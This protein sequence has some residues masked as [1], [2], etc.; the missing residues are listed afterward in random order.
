MTN[1]D[2]R[3]KNKKRAAA[4]ALRDAAIAEED[5]K[6]AQ[7]RL[8]NME[9]EE[10][11]SVQ[12]THDSLAMNRISEI[13]SS[14]RNKAQRKRDHKENVAKLLQSVHLAAAQLHKVGAQLP[15]EAEAEL[16]RNKLLKADAAAA[17]AKAKLKRTRAML[18]RLK[19]ARPIDNLTQHDRKKWE[20]VSQITQIDEE[21]RNGEGHQQVAAPTRYN[22]KQTRAYKDLVGNA[23]LNAMKTIHGN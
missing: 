17:Q 16:L 2:K 1:R 5:A 15:W 21:P 9:L 23:V 20:H 19:K 11:A 13:L 3:N 14:F 7:K 12:G 22:T 18:T 6:I 10:T 4:K 8:T